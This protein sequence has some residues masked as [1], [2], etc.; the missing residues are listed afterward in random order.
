MKRAMI[1]LFLALLF[2]PP[3]AG[4]EEQRYAVPILDSPSLGPD[5]APVTIIEFLDFQ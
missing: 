2:L 3:S 1:P 4:A 5:N